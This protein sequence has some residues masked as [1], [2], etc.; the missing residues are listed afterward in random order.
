M[1][2]YPSP[3][4][5][6]TRLERD[7]FIV[8]PLTGE[9]VQRDYAAVM[10]SRE[11]LRRWGGTTWPTDDFDLA[12]NLADLEMH[13]A[14]HRRR[15]AFTYTVLSP[16]AMECLGC[17]YIT[18]LSRLVDANPGLRAEERDAVVG[19]WAA[20]TP[21]GLAVEAELAA[22]LITWLGNAWRFESVAFAVR[23]ELTE[24]HRLLEELGLT[25]GAQITVP[26]RTGVFTLFDL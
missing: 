17:V 11:M 19:F 12:G 5:I 9:H 6:P 26:N 22:E 3:L 7:S 24:Q 18:P 16:D 21:R 4:P 8:E 2:F 15:D 1:D 23:D 25:A 13:D 20:S 14:E 10:A